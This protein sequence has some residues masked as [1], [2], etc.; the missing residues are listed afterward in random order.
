MT[1]GKSPRGEMSGGEDRGEMPR[2][3]KSCHP[4][5]YGKRAPGGFNIVIVSRRLLRGQIYCAAECYRKLEHQKYV[6]MHRPG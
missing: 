3:E 5:I 4:E 2:G 1:G 6:N